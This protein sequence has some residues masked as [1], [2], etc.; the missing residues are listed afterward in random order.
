MSKVI[1][2]KVVPSRNHKYRLLKHKIYLDPDNTDNK[3]TLEKGIIML[4]TLD[5][6]IQGVLS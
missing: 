6:E 4:M 2:W 3:W 1:G 5:T